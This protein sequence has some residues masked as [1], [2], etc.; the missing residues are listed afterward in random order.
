MNIRFFF[1]VLYRSIV[2]AS[3]VGVIGLFLLVFVTFALPSSDGW[4]LLRFISTVLFCFIF[5]GSFA[6]RALR[7]NAIEAS[8]KPLREWL[9]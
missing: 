2:V 5:V 7:E 6:D 3:G 9:K 4:L 1:T 8:E